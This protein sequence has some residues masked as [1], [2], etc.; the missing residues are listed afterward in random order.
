MLRRALASVVVGSMSDR[1]PTV[2]WK[3]LDQRLVIP[4][5]VHFKWDE[6]KHQFASV[7]YEIDM[8]A[9]LTKVLGNLEDVCMV[10]NSPS[11]ILA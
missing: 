7:Y 6:A 9:P 2:A 11:G 1:W 10:L 3:L 5:T 4:G 8:L